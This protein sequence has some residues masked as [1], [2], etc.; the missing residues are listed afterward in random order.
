MIAYHCVANLIM[1]VPFN[2]G[3]DTYRRIACDKIMQRL[4]NH[5]ITVDQKIL[6]REASTEYYFLLLRI[7]NEYYNSYKARGAIK[8]FQLDESF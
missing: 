7:I 2:T 3:K 4:S 5:K 8:L 6:D 1:T